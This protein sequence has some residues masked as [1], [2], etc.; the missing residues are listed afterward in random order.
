MEYDFPLETASLV[1]IINLNPALEA[2][3]IDIYYCL[4]RYTC[5]QDTDSLTSN[6]HV[7]K[8]NQ[9][10][11]ASLFGFHSACIVKLTFSSLTLADGLLLIWLSVFGLSL[12]IEAGLF[13]SSYCRECIHL[14][15]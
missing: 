6:L 15:M 8:S 7:I 1:V 3:L 9:L 2:A 10:S 5:S 13:L 11:F 12:V 14:V 4:P